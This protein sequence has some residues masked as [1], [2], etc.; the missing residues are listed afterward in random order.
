MIT[1]RNLKVK[2]YPNVNLKTQVLVQRNV[3]VKIFTHLRHASFTVNSAR[4][5]LY[6]AVKIDILM[7][8]VVNGRSIIHATWVYHVDTA[9]RLINQFFLLI[10]IFYT[11]VIQEYQLG[12]SGP[13][14]GELTG[15]RI[16]GKDI[17][18]DEETGAK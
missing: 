13:R 14:G 18:T 11:Q 16:K 15:T 4:V 7:E 9:T 10:T 3:N 12:T 1:E 2:L 8:C 5:H 6:Q 17:R